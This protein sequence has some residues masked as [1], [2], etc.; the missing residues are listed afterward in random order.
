MKKGEKESDYMV[1]LNCIGGKVGERGTVG[2]LEGVSFGRIL[3]VCGLKLTT[4]KVILWYVA[5]G[6]KRVSIRV[7]TITSGTNVK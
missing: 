2:R 5:S 6:D 1:G 4:K 3:V 7:S